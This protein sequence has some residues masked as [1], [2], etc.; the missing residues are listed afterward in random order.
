MN[1]INRY[2]LTFLTLLATT[3]TW[4][5]NITFRIND[6][7][8]GNVIA[9]LS[10]NTNTQITTANKNDV[11]WLIASPVQNYILSS[12]NLKITAYSD[13]GRADTRTEPDVVNTISF[14]PVGG[15][16]NTY[17]FTMPDYDVVV[18][19]VFLHLIF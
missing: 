3:A 17:S 8:K 7:N 15:Q 2:I 11:V 16:A 5:Y 19:A 9:V 12:N 14:S 4:G 6:T 18:D 1:K 10:T 13:P